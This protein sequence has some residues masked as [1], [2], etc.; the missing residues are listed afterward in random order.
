MTILTNIPFKRQQLYIHTA[1]SS[2]TPQ[3]FGIVLT[4]IWQ[5][6]GCINFI[7]CEKYDLRCLPSSVN[8]EYLTF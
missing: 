5:Q 7:I 2:V 3:I 1:V 6:K 4:K 8:K